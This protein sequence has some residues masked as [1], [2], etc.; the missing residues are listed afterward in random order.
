MRRIILT[1]LCA[2]YLITC[3]AQKKQES[4]VISYYTLYR[5]FE[6]TPLPTEREYLLKITKS[7]SV[8]EECLPQGDTVH[9]PKLIIK[10]YP[11]DGHLTFTGCPLKRVTYTE[12]IPQFEWE[13]EEGDAAVCG[14]HCQSAK[15]SFRGRTW[16][17]WYTTD[18]P[19]DDD[20]GNCAD[21][22]D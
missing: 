12:P 13:L 22:P 11:K 5:Y 17:V 7:S 20:H 14:Y 4:L 9:E 2:A 19:I 8:F 3:H 10:N 1:I 6:E 16:T 21:C 15:T 18:I